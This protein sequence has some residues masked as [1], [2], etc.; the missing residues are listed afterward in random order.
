T[1]VALVAAAD[2]AW[3]RP[4]E[5]AARQQRLEEL[6]P[7]VQRLA[8]DF[9]NVLTSLL[10][11]SELALDRVPPRHP[12]SGDPAEIHRSAPEGPRLT[13]QWRLANRRG[14]VRSHPVSLAAVA[15]ET[16]A[17]WQP[18]RPTGI[19]LQNLIPADLPAVA[20]DGELLAQLL[21]HLLDNAREALADTAG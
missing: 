11:F 16:T 15:S 10:G 13:N 18:E 20:A 3:A 2:P 6:A 9:C 14:V 1:A 7:I 4:L 12:L 5:Q 19:R 8:P 21:V 17:R